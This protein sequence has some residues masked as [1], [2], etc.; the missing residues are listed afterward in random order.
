MTDKY[1]VQYGFIYLFNMWDGENVGERGQLHGGM[2]CG[3]RKRD[4]FTS[5]GS[6][7][8]YTFLF[9]CFICCFNS[10]FWSDRERA[11]ER[12]RDSEC[13]LYQQAFPPAQC[14]CALEH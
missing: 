9:H 12:E 10:L 8:F 4:T 11:S 5:I 14:P 3:G 13:I 6:C 7:T 1:N 2:N